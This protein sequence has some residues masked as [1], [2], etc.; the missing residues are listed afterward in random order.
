M[1]KLSE[2]LNRFNLNAQVF[3]AGDVCGTLGFDQASP[4]EGHMHLVRQGW[5]Q[6][7]GADATIHTIERPSLIFMAKSLKHQLRAQVD[8]AAQVV[9]A[10]IVYGV[11]NN[12]P[13]ANAFP[14]ILILPLD[15]DPRLA[16][17]CNWLF[18]EAFA[19]L[20]G[21]QLAIN[22]LAELLVLQ[23]LRHLVERAC[24]QTG[25]LAGLAHPQLHKALLAIHSEPAHAWS[26]AELSSLS[27]MSRS[28]FA[29]E[30]KRVLG[31]PPGDYLIEWRLGV[32]QSLLR[33][34]KPVG[35]VAHEV[36]YENA[37]VLAR[38]FRKKLGLTPLEWLERQRDLA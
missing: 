15:E 36:G 2:V 1:L 5:V 10:S 13:L 16:F 17:V 30:F 24:L 11:G 31:Q 26:L 27:G 23:M 38:V 4:L 8:A 14:A 35:L 21:R 37:S 22:R 9:C 19:Q 20:E 18:D 12:N 32:A 7:Q 33:Q 29:E 6:I 28:K 25:M 3:Y 34:L